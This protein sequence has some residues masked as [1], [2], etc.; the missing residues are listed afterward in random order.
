LP[1]K[2]EVVEEELD[3]IDAPA[4]TVVHT[5]TAGENLSRIAAQYYDDP[6]Q[7]NVIY[8]A[9]RERIGSN[10]DRLQAGMKIV[11]PPALPR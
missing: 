7:W 6:T 8:N 3:D 10:P 5:V 11:I 4:N 9:N 2:S 1:D